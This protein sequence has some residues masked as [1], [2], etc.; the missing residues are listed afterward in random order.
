MKYIALLGLALLLLSAC[1]KQVVV[2]QEKSPCSSTFAFLHLEGHDV[3]FLIDENV[4]YSG[5][6]TEVDESTGLNFSVNLS[7]KKNSRIELVID[8]TSF[9]ETVQDP[10]AAS[11]IYLSNIYQDRPAIT[12]TDHEYLLLD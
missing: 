10:C 1:E 8:G 4:E 2:K 11:V 5:K 12:V 9:S 3:K 7:L 6:I